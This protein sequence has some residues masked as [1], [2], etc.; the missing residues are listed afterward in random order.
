MI[1]FLDTCD[2]I[3]IILPQHLLI[4]VEV[5]L[6]NNTSNI[7]TYGEQMSIPFFKGHNNYNMSNHTT[8]TTSVTH[9]QFFMFGSDNLIGVKSIR[10]FNIIRFKIYH[11]NI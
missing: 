3:S 1:I 4:F 7:L 9:V 10:C 11:W 6:K 2:I 5:S 8:R